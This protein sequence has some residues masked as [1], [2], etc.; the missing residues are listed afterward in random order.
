MVFEGEPFLGQDRLDLL[1]WRLE[2]AGLQE[3][4]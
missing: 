4:H 1:Q 2:K 3:R